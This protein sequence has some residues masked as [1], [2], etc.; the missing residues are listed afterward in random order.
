[1]KKHYSFVFLRLKLILVLFSLISFNP[2]TFSRNGTDNLTDLNSITTAIAN[3]TTICNDQVNDSIQK[4]VRFDHSEN[5]YDYYYVKLSRFHSKSERLDFYDKGRERGI[6]IVDKTNIFNDSACFMTTLQKEEALFEFQELSQRTKEESSQHANLINAPTDNEYECSSAGVACSA[7]I[8]SFPAGTSGEAPPPVDGYPNY[9]CLG[10]YP[11]PAWYYM[12]V[13]IPGDIIIDISQSGNHDVDFIC[14]GPFTSLTDGCATGLTGT[15]G[16]PPKFPENCCTNTSLGCLHFYPRGNIVD[17]SYSG[18]AN[19]TCHIYNAQ[20]DEIYI[21][22]MTNFSQDPGTI[23][24][25]QTGGSGVTNCNI[26]VF[27]SMIAITANPSTCNESTNTFSASGN[28]EFSNAPPT[29]T[30]TITDITATPPVFQTFLPP[31]I[32]PLPYNLTNIPCDGVT[33][34]L[35]AVF[36]DSLNCTLTQQYPSP[37]A[38]CPQAQ[39]NGGGNICNDGSS[40]TTV[41]INIA[42][43]PGP[44]DFTYA[45]NGISQAPITNYSGTFPYPI[46]TKIPGLYTLASVSNQVCPTGGT[47]SGSATVAL[48]PLPTANI[49][50]T[51]AVCLNSTAPLVT[52]TGGSASSP[53][54]FTY[55]I[56]GGTNQ[57]VTTTIGNSVTISVPTNVAVVYTYNLVSVQDGSSLA[58]SQSQTGSATV[59]VN[60]LPTA[61]ITGTTTVCQNST[62]PK[63]TFTGGSATP[64]YTFT[65]NIGGGTNQTVSTTVGNSVTVDVPTNTIGT[66]TYNLVSIQDGSSTMCS[67]LQTGTATVTVNSL[68]TGTIEG[69]TVVC[70]NAVSPLITL[71]GGAS[72]P[73]YTFTYNINDGTN[74]TV[75]TTIGNSVTISVPTDVVGTFIYNLVSVQDGSSTACFQLQTGSATITI[76]PLPTATISGTTTVCQ[77]STA[78]QITFTGGS[79]TPPYTFTYNIGGGTNQTVS[80]TIGNS[81][82]VDAPTN[83]VGAFTYNLVSVQDGSS[84]ACSQMQTGNA[85][86]TINPL[87]TA[88]I[89]GS[90]AV[91]QNAVSPLITFTGESSLPPYTFTYNIN[92]GADLTVTT[93]VGNS[94]TVTVPTNVPG[95]FVYNL[96]RVQDGSSTACSQQI[97]GIA[98]VTIHPLPVSTFTGSAA[99]C[100]LHPD[101]YL[102]PANSGPA[103][104]YTWSVNPSSFG[105]IANATVSPASITW[106]TPGTATLRLDA[107]TPFG[108]A[109]FSSQPI[110]INPRP[111]V[112]IT[113]CFDPVTS[114]SAKRFLLKGGVPLLTAT[115]LQGE[116]LIN[117]PTVALVFESGNYYFDPTLVP[118]TNTINYNIYYKYTSSRFGCPATS[119]NSVTLT[120]HGSNPTCSS[121]MTD[122]R[123]NTTYRTSFAGGKCWMMENL[124]YGTSLTPATTV[125]SDNCVAEKYCLSSDVNCTRYGGF[126]QWN[127]LIQYGVTASPEYQGVCPPGWHIPSSADFQALID[128]N[129]GN[130]LAGATLTDLNLNPRGFEALFTGMAY[131]NTAWAFTSSNVPAGTLFWTST[132]GSGNKI[133]TRGMNNKVP[134]VSLYETSGVNAFPVRCVKD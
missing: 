44:Y 104:S 127:E 92:D 14:W 133:V 101:A 120:V 87:P 65:Y 81:V 80:T 82:K 115:P 88:T 124:R 6:F 55:N 40:Q 41:N 20:I 57:T 122:Y 69:T 7:N 70:H 134:S 28:I 108:C 95:T 116:Y 54:T 37:P 131:L 68:P 102:Y 62:V 34:S 30:L 24:F 31:F 103:C 126:Y 128:A 27:C 17:C 77:N 130:A 125:Q 8:Y 61:T 4:T 21:L 19:E 113:P 36:S 85:T 118:G 74:Q 63:I 129:Q 117:P 90:T 52:F 98:T 66:F 35:T 59:T 18:S 107:V 29:G 56:N 42:G 50:G 112:S 47:V 3:D 105:S 45:I 22:L 25:S 132:P 39:I 93:N 67:Q 110:T 53:Y 111:D 83:A 60:P 96:I 72:L 76:N 97:S 64:P 32:S 43:S 49:E 79:A 119:S 106:N 1:M 91:C 13:G 11:C 10:S 123:D 121:S 16:L 12:Q 48:K 33:H 100:Q 26:V 38:S 109:S 2:D 5:G 94:A 46:N 86:V 23:T 84:T 71:T 73:P 114:R 75:T 15:C 9:G 51:T 99:V 58:C 89:V 78:P